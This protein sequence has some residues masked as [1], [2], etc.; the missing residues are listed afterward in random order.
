[1]IAATFALR[2]LPASDRVSDRT[3]IAG[4]FDPANVPLLMGVL[5][6]AP[7]MAA[8]A[9]FQPLR[10]RIQVAVDRRFDRAWYDGQ[11][12]A[13]AFGDRRRDQVDLEGIRA[14]IPVSLDTAVRPTL[15]LPLR[16][17]VQ[18]AVD[19]RFDRATYSGEQ[20]VSELGERL[21]DQVDLQTI[22][23][24]IPATIDLAARPRHVGLWLRSGG[25]GVDR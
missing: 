6:T 19:R 13:G 5:L 21:R 25:G 12:L 24:E 22:R 16:G 8:F 4:L 10:R 7:T 17:R 1:M 3:A 23:A 15:F 2:L 18:R 20:L 14:D 11:Q 9:L